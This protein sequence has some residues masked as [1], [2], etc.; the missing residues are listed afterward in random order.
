METKEKGTFVECILPC[1]HRFCLQCVNLLEASHCP[2][3]RH[4][5]SN[6]SSLN[7]KTLQLLRQVV[8]EQ[9]KY[10]VEERVSLLDQQNNDPLINMED[11]LFPASI[12]APSPTAQVRRRRNA[13][14]SMRNA[15]RGRRT[16]ARQSNILRIAPDFIDDSQMSGALLFDD[17]ELTIDHGIH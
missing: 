2:L 10:A 9:A 16:A 15:T 6:G 17:I 14:R 1:D 7:G 5:F 3:C 8:E 4:S 11:I 12:R 13:T